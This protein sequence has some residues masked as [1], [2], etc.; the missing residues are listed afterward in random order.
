MF[1]RIKEDIDT[2]FDQDPA[3]RSSLEVI[4]TYSGLHAIWAHRIAHAF[5]KRRMYFIARIISQIARFFTGI[6]IHPGATIGRRFFIDHG[7]G[8]VIGETCIIGNNV[9]VYQGVTLGGTGKEKGKRHPTVKDN[10]LIATGAKVL[11]NITI[12]ENSKVGAGSVVLKD[13]PNNSTVVGIPGRI[14]IQDGVKIGKDLNHS[15]LPDPML[16]KFLALENQII[17]LQKEI[18][19]G[20]VYNDNKNL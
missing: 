15:D 7:M 10:A 19:K 16:D 8:V 4:L 1:K 18:E 20:A 9:T 17:Q 12:G 5:Y 3:A 11:G 2:V 6:E 14:V 13:V